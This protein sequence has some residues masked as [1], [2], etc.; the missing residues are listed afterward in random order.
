[1][2]A[3]VLLCAIVP[4]AGQPGTFVARLLIT[5]CQLQVARIRQDCAGSNTAMAETDGDRRVK[6]H[7]SFIGLKD[8]MSYREACIYPGEGLNCILVRIGPFVTSRF[9]VFLRW[10]KKQEGSSY[11]CSACKSRPLKLENSRWPFTREALRS[12]FENAVRLE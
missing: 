5:C 10:T 3:S 4:S 11:I 12:I 1:M 8:F 6:C 2:M 7:V 9:A